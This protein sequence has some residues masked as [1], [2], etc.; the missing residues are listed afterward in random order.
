MEHGPSLHYIFS[1]Y[2]VLSKQDIK[3]R[4]L[5]FLFSGYKH[6][7][8]LQLSLPVRLPPSTAC[9]GEDTEHSRQLRNYVPIE[10]TNALNFTI[11]DAEI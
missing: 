1:I 7:P 9:F 4:N 6:T 5:Q 11:Y 8:N 2:Q 10:D 3:A